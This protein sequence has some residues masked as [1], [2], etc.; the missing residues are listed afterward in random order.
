MWKQNCLCDVYK[1]LVVHGLRLVS[2]VVGA[3]FWISKHWGDKGRQGLYA[4][5]HCALE[6]LKTVVSSFLSESLFLFCLFLVVGGPARLVPAGGTPP[7]L[8]AGSAPP[9]R[10]LTP[11]A[12]LQRAHP[13]A[14]LAVACLQLGLPCQCSS[15]EQ[16]ARPASLLRV[17][18]HFLWDGRWCRA[19]F[20]CNRITF[21]KYRV[22]LIYCQ[23][24]VS[25]LLMISIF[26]FWDYS[27]S[28]EFQSSSLISYCPC[29]EAAIRIKE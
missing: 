29:T 1:Y 22:F 5:R 3:V 16:K 20:N 25:S 15:R 6:T 9:L 10:A 2:E 8:G 7:W 13:L 14:C 27:V 18:S 19:R 4:S 23:Y 21:S 28:F 11:C 24:L 17:S 12:R 26:Y